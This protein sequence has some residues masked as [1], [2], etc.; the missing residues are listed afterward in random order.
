M[1]SEAGWLQAPLSVDRTEVGEEVLLSVWVLQWLCRSKVLQSSIGPHISTVFSLISGPCWYFDTRLVKSLLDVTQA[2][3]S[4]AREGCSRGTTADSVCITRPHYNT[5]KQTKE[6]E[7]LLQPGNSEFHLNHV[8][9][10]GFRHALS[11]VKSG[12]RGG[13]SQS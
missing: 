3:N 1:F 13:K 11:S 7:F 10:M 12:G 2:C 5:Q 9:A 6:G 4:S 8:R